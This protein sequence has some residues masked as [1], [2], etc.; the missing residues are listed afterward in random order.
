VTKLYVDIET[1]SRI[2][3]KKTGV[4]RYVKCPDWR[5]LMASWAIDSGPVQTALGYED[6]N[7]IPGLWD[8]S[9]VKVAHNA[10]FER[11]NFSEFRSRFPRSAECFCGGPS[12]DD[13]WAYCNN[14][15]G[16]GEERYLP[17]E[18]WTN[19]TQAL[20]AEWGYPQSLAMA[21]K[22]IGGEQ[23]DE[24]GTR[25]INLFCKP[26]RKGEWNGPHTHPAEWLDFIAYCE[27]DVETMR[28]IDNHVMG[29]GGWPTEIERQVY[30]ADQKVNDRGIAIDTSMARK[31]ELAALENQV[32]QLARANEITG[33][34]NANSVEQFGKWLRQQGVQAPNLRAE[35]V[36]RLLSTDLA[37][38]VRE[39]LEL[40]QELALSASKKFGAALGAVLPDGRLRGTMKFFGAHTG[41]WAGRGTQPQN[42]P[43]AAFMRTD[44]NGKKVHDSVAED[45]A[46]LDLE[47]G[48]GGDAQTL[49]KLVRPM[50]L[51]PTGGTIVDYA[52]IEA[53]VIAWLANEDWALEAFRKGRDIYVETA[54]RMGGLTRAQGKIAVLALGYN[55]AAGSLR[56]MAT[57]SD[58]FNTKTDKQ[59]MSEYV[60]PWRKANSRIVKLWSDMDTAFARG[61]KVGEHLTFEVDGKDRYLRLPSGR[62]IGYHD[63]GATRQGDRVRLYFRSS[64]GYRTDTYGGRLAENATQAVARDI[65]AEALVRLEEKGFRVVAHVHDEILVE[66]QHDVEEIS[67][68]MTESP[69]WAYG[70]PI[71]GEG[72]TCRRYRKG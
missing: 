54:E 3:L 39:A 42:L 30:I 66:G 63:V 60:Y 23:K 67:S 58:G 69:S 31:A 32:A 15:C 14:E 16:I 43:R 12:K 1:R 57:D 2:D 5:I 13:P 48:L 17:P 62:V 53:R 8:S 70:L 47:M 35:T 37:P 29:L 26:N 22:V 34:E 20:V 46:I 56:A 44:E 50:F 68:I 33:L 45:A 25:L 28:D 9:V 7:N 64:Q 11:V 72:F 18:D 6:I 10:Q 65:L 36:E 40:R 27:Q 24:A 21:A 61:G 52:A 51:H 19:D 71:D 55:G 59:L 41:R 49:K 38:T 4:Y